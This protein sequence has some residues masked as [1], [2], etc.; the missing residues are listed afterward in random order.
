MESELMARYRRELSEA[1]ANHLQQLQCELQVH[2]R[3][4]EVLAGDRRNQDLAAAAIANAQA[5]Q[6][7][8]ARDIALRR[9]FHQYATVLREAGDA[10]AEIQQNSHGGGH[11][12]LPGRLPA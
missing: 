6:E 5:A 8:E 12:A 7:A 3:Q 11:H 2:Q 1:E 9:E 4:A 10:D